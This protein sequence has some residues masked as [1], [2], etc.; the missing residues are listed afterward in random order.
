MIVSKLAVE[1][2]GLQRYLINYFAFHISSSIFTFVIA[3]NI[4][5]IP[6]LYRN[7]VITYNVQSMY[8]QNLG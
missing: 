8:L 6:I 1:Y 7:N 3:E 4:I 2:Q 5:S